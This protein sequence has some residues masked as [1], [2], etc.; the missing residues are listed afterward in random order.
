MLE[1]ALQATTAIE[2]AIDALDR[3][4]TAADAQALVDEGK[5]AE[6]EAMYQRALAGQEK[7]LGPE[8]MST[9]DTVGKLCNLYYKQRLRVW[10]PRQTPS[11]SSSLAQTALRP[12][13]HR[14]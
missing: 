14:P 4:R 10:M 7:A 1:M 13:P 8:R 2:R 11:C 12:G 6:A 9:L 3:P 5:L